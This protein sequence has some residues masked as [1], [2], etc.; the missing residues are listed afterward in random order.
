MKKMGFRGLYNFLSYMAGEELEN[1]GIFE[2]SL[3]YI[4]SKVILKSAKNFG[5][6]QEE[7]ARAFSDRAVRRGFATVLR[8]LAE[9]GITMPQRLPA[10]FLVVW[11]F[12]RMCNLNCKHCYENATREM[13]KDELSLEEKLKVVEILDEAGVAAI[14]FSGG[15]PLIH[16]H[17]WEVAKEAA[18]RGFYVSVATNGTIITEEVAKRMKEI[19][20]RYVEVSLDSPNPEEHDE[21]RGV[22]GA[23]ERAVNGIK[24][25]VKADLI[26]GVAMTATKRTYKEVPE[27]I[28]LAKKLGAKRFV[29]FSFIPTGRAKEI[30]DLDLSAEEKRY[31]LDCLYQALKRKEIEAYSTSPAYAVTSLIDIEG[32]PVT[33][34]HFGV[35]EL[36]EQYRSAARSLAEFIGGCGAGRIYM[37]IQPNGDVTPCVF[38]PDV[39][40]GNL[41]RDGFEKIWK[42][43]VFEMLRDRDNP[44]YGCYSC[45]YKYVCG[46]CRARAYAYTGSLIGAEPECP[47]AD[48]VK[49]E[50]KERE[51]EEAIER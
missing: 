36:P 23:W 10:P 7:L 25:A 44:E 43:E 5:V 35:R 31:V 28:E 1:M 33:M 16:P 46:G 15:E 38:I 39:V 4:I 11:N 26:V 12:T 27:M 30:V 34:A 24:N 21:F 20:V 37:A 17:F 47:Y 9:Y 19:G 45:P 2:R 50:V 49:Q 14:A 29:V 51:V 22:P 42:C 3:Y 41:L 40:V 48:L 6:G 13:P 8:G 32:G 18:S